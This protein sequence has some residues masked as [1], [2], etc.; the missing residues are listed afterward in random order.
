M[1]V[2]LR[3]IDCSHSPIGA[4][5]CDHRRDAGIRCRRKTTALNVYEVYSNV[6]ESLLKGKGY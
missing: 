5:N 3:L 2:N 4:H 1:E 6:L